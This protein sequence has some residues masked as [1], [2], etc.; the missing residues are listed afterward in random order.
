V[1]RHCSHLERKRPVTLGAREVVFHVHPRA[2]RGD[3]IGRFRR[4][5]AAPLQ[6]KFF[7]GIVG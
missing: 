3:I 2:K 4:V 7:R 6:S 5:Q 1:I